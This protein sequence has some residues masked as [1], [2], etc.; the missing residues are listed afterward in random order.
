MDS[1]NEDSPVQSATPPAV[2]ST[3]KLIYVV[4]DESMIGEVVEVILKLKG[5]KPKFFVDPELALQSLANEDPKPELLLTDF[6]MSPM[7]GMELIERSKQIQPSL[8]T[9]LYSGNVGEEIMQYYS[10]KP[11][12]F[13]S[14]PFMP[15]TLVAVV[16]SVLS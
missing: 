15:K 12:G 3:P 13:V 11:D 6:L 1:K 16:K 8:K 7:N 4:D 2:E 10:V 9:I 14:K 5:F